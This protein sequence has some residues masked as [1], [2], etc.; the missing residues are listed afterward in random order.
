MTYIPLNVKIVH[1][2]NYFDKSNQVIKKVRINGSGDIITS[3]AYTDDDKIAKIE[4]DKNTTLQFVIATWIAGTTYNKTLRFE[5]ENG[6]KLSFQVGSST[7]T[8]QIFT[9]PAG[10]KYVYAPTSVT[11]FPDSTNLLQMEEGSIITTYEAYESS[12]IQLENQNLNASF[13]TNAKIT[14]PITEPSHAVSKEYVEKVEL[15]TAILRTTYE[16]PISDFPFSHKIQK[17]GNDYITD[18]NWSTLKN[19]ITGT[20]CYVDPVNGNNANTGTQGSPFKSVQHVIANTA[21][22]IVYLKPGFYANTEGFQGQNITRNMSFLRD[23]NTGN[24]LATTHTP[25]TYTADPTYTNTYT[26]V[27]GGAGNPSVIADMANMDADNVPKKL[28]LVASAALVNTTINSYYYDSATK[29]VWIRTFNSRVPDSNILNLLDNA[30]F[31]SWHV[32][33]V[34]AENI[35]FYGGGDPA[36]VYVSS[37]TVPKQAVFVNCEFNYSIGGDNLSVSSNVYISLSNCIAKYSNRDGFNYN[38]TNIRFF[39][40]KCVGSDNGTT[41]SDNGST[42]HNSAVGIRVACTYLRNSGGCLHDIDS[43]KSYNVGIIAGF[44]IASSIS[45][46]G[47]RIGAYNVADSTL[48]YLIECKSV[49]THIGFQINLGATAHIVNG[50]TGNYGSSNSDVFGTVIFDNIYRDSVVEPTTLQTNY[51]H[52]TASTFNISTGYLAFIFDGTNATWRLPPIA[53][54]KGW[55]M[56]VYNKG[57]GN[58][59][60]NSNS[61]GNDIWDSSYKNTITIL[62]GEVWRAFNDGTTFNFS[63]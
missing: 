53:S 5:D 32:S 20:T 26:A 60:I 19:S 23:G 9:P 27:Y 57:T 12:I 28:T 47:Y 54:S 63:N 35:K 29:T 43:A 58:L 42:S 25:L 50:T 30:N 45:Q 39:E 46:R 8:S 51:V 49:G 1:G 55:L 59:T 21:F 2:K 37:A 16:Y 34:Y 11:G 44:S 14:T 6:N 40:Y 17:V 24:V 36:Y 15:G 22:N 3:G 52:T 10:T 41:Q 4:I 33:S 31:Y 18:F 48:A 13:L 56:I 7:L 38:G 62:S 61:G